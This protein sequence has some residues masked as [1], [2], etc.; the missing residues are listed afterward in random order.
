MFRAFLRCLIVAGLFIATGAT[1]A[2]GSW[3]VR[4][5]AID[6][7]PQ[8]SADGT[9]GVLGAS[10]NSQWAPEVDLTYF[11]TRNIGVEVIAATT[12]HDVSSSIGSLGSTKV[13]PPTVTLQWHFMPD[14]DFRPYVGGGIN[15]TRFYDV[16]LHAGATPVN[17]DQNS[18][19]GALQLGFDYKVGDKVYLN[20]DVKKIWIKTD[21]TLATTGASLGTLTLNPYVFGAG[22]GYRF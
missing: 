14:S 5:R 13:L 8:S 18:W 21:A 17:V 19:G 22:V 1:A 2:D 16:N 6:V 20:L 3:L 12:K 10:A 9:L 15:Y 7:D 11:F 4:L